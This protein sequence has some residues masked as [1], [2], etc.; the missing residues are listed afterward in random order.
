MDALRDGWLRIQRTES[1]LS[2][3]D[4]PWPASGEAVTSLE[5]R[6]GALPAELTQQFA[7]VFGE[8]MPWIVS[9]QF[10][11]RPHVVPDFASNQLIVLTA[12]GPPRTSLSSRTSHR[13]RR[14]ECRDLLPSNYTKRVEVDPDAYSRCSFARD[15]SF[16]TRER[17]A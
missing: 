15:D 14:G 5:L 17:V 10:L 8:T 16:S 2:I 4:G 6:A 3:G 1:Q 9:S 13:R 7:G 11:V 12:E